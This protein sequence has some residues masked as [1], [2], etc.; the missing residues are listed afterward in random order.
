MSTLDIHKDIPG[1]LKGRYDIVHVRLLLTVV[2]NDDP[3]PI[4]ENLMDMLSKQI[5]PPRGKADFKSHECIEPGGFLQWSEHNIATMKVVTARP[6]A[7]ASKVEFLVNQAKA[8]V[9][10]KSVTCFITWTVHR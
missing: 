1:E 10:Y 4:L 6:E 7:N 9:R 5:I 8:A 2:K 3:S